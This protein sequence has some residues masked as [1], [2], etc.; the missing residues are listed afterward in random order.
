MQDLEE[1]KKDVGNQSFG[2]LLDTAHEL[3]ARCESAE[4]DR[5]D[6]LAM[7]GHIQS[8][9]EGLR[10]IWAERCHEFMQRNKAEAKLKELREQKPVAFSLSFAPPRVN[11]MT[12]FSTED[13]AVR[14]S[15]WCKLPAPIVVPLYAT[16][17]AQSLDSA[18]PSDHVLMPKSLTAENGAKSLFMG[19]FS[20]Q[21]EMT[22]PECA[23]EEE[24]DED[25]VICNGSVQYL[26]KVPVSWS[27]VKDIYAMAVSKLALPPQSNANAYSEQVQG[28][29]Q[30]ANETGMLGHHCA[31]KCQYGQQSPAVAAPEIT[32]ALQWLYEVCSGEDVSIP[33][34]HYAAVA[35]AA[36]VLAAPQAS[37]EQRDKIF[38]IGQL[39][40]TLDCV[41][42]G[43]AWVRQDIFDIVTE[44]T[45][46]TAAEM[47]AAAKQSAQDEGKV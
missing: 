2:K 7:I 34:R 21:M 46:K 17:V 30:Y 16:P 41:D 12:T 14:Y 18:E 45:G 3:I 43:E 39:A 38:K 29:C 27:T 40:A 20:E 36:S 23:D 4:K 6:L 5:D 13:D 33:D 35:N 28:Y 9:A 42:M 47:F 15:N 19:E 25:C 44:L 37:A 8:G 31:V 1:L 10:K 32:Q 22:C 11:V 24:H 26:Q